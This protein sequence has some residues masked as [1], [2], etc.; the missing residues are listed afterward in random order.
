MEQQ[1]RGT[2]N[3][4]KDK[5]VFDIAVGTNRNT[6]K[7]YNRTLT[8]TEFANKF[9]EPIR[10]KETLQEYFNYETAIQ[11]DI[12]DVGGFVGG[13]LI[14]GKR[15]IKNVKHRQILCFDL[16]E[17][18]EGYFPNLG[19]Y[20]GII[21]T[22]HKHTKTNPRYRVLI[23][24]YAPITIEEYEYVSRYIADKLGL[25]KSACLTTF[26]A[27]RLMYWPSCSS[28]GE[29]HFKSVEGEMV[30]GK[31]IILDNPDWKCTTYTSSDEHIGQ[32]KKEIVKKQQDPTTKGGV[33]GAFCTVFSIT[34]IIEKYLS[35]KYL[36]TDTKDR[37]TWAEGS[38]AK[39]VL[40]FEDK[41]TYSFH[42]TDPAAMR[43]NNGYD[44]LR[45]LKFKGN[46]KNTLDFCAKQP[47]I[48]RILAKEEFKDLK[49][50]EWTKDLKYSGAGRA[51]ATIENLKLIIDNNFDIKFNAFNQNMTYAGQPYKNK[52]DS[53]VL[54]VIEKKYGVY[55]V[56]KTKT[57]IDIVSTKNE[58]HPIR[59]WLKSLTWDGKPRLDSLLID[60]F[61]AKDTLFTREAIR[62][63]LVGGVARIFEPGVEVQHILVLHGPQDIGKSYFFEMLCPDK[64]YYSDSLTLYDIKDTKTGSEALRGKWLL[65]IP[66]M[67]GMKKAETE[68]IKAYVVRKIDTYRPSYALRTENFPR[69]CIFFA[70]TNKDFLQDITGNRRFW[71]IDCKGRLLNN[72]NRDQIWA[73]AKYLYQNG[74]SLRL[75]PEAKELSKVE[76]VSY[77]E[78]DDRLQFVEQFITKKVPAKW[79]D[80]TTFERIGYMEDELSGKE[81]K[82]LIDRKWITTAE[83]WC[84]VFKYH[85]GLLKR[86]ES[87][88]IIKIL[89]KLGYNEYVQNCYDKNYGRCRGYKKPTN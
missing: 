60:Y 18:E 9:R 8:W 85:K 15:S 29:Y 4:V 62:K 37:Y 11:D 6:A 10:T 77:L 43:L 7:W 67:A 24:L 28:N 76:E 14:G 69:Q 40:V 51:L 50:E 73:E 82:D 74:E 83:V 33:I 38:T 80:M 88:E 59:D 35:D 89:Q 63:T 17:G 45:I 42:G 1:K 31:G 86:Q 32:I 64:D 36:Q 75:S 78:T 16:D 22:T 56:Q 66:E 81:D 72:I 19:N 54:S 68:A 21:H 46:E 65:E 71:I 2:D 12:K 25:I 61:A 87:N 3:M 44:L 27:N 55:N 30:D 53:V 47:G 79:Y 34:E 5:I 26:Q 23:P 57:A 84:E 41:F 20:M 13:Y 58:Y 39:G 48:G 52:F 49:N 70:S